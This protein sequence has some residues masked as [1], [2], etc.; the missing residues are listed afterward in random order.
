MKIAACLGVKDEVELVRAAIT[1]LRA[2][3]IDHIIAS[4]A[5]STDGTEAILAEFAQQPGFE[6][7]T[8]DDVNMDDAKE[9][10]AT[11]DVF[12]LA[13]AAGA[14]WLLFCDADE[15]P[16]PQTGNLRDV[17]ALSRADAIIIP[18]FNIPLMTEGLGLVIKQG[19]WMADQVLVYAPNEDRV[20]TQ[21]RVRTDSDAP[22][23]ASIPGPKLLARTAKITST[24]EAHHNIVA[25]DGARVVTE[26]PGDL[27]IAHVPFSTADRFARKVDNIRRLVAESGAGWAPDSAWHWR[28]WLDNIDTRGG[29]AGEMARNTVTQA[30]VAELWNA[31]VIKSAQQVWD[32]RV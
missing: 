23:I 20:V 4:D 16:M 31:G 5:N 19:L 11:E 18:R 21:S 15:F 2:I 27:F 6:V 13:R 7:C 32:R 28:R 8:F 29:V 12:A 17:A 24:A 26:V 9:M 1:H 22:W 25:A 14:D 10:Q 3:G 30:Q